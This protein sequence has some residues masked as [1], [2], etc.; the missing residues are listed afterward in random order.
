M[1]QIQIDSRISSGMSGQ[2]ALAPVTPAPYRDT[3]AATAEIKTARRRIIA[4][5]RTPITGLA[6]PA[7]AGTDSRH[8]TGVMQEAGREW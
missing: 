8:D 3:R 4:N 5:L 2:H 1:G 6:L 7:C